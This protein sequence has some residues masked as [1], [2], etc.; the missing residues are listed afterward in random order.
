M[1]ELM[2]AIKAL[3]KKHGDNY[4]S[5]GLAF[6]NLTRHSTGIDALDFNIGGGLPEKRI[7]MLAGEY[8]SGKTTAWIN[9]AAQ[10]QK[11]GGQVV[12]LNSE[13]VFDPIW[14]AKFGL[15]SEKLIVVP[16]SCV[17]DLTDVAET[18]LMSGEVDLLV[19]D[20]VDSTPS[21]KE[22]EESA[23]K[24]SYGGIAKSVSLFMK[25]MIQVLHNPNLKLKTTIVIV[26]HIKTNISGYGPSQY[27]P[28]GKSLHDFSD[29]IIWLKRDSE[30]LGEKEKPV[31]MTIKLHTKKN[32][33]SV[34]FRIGSYDLHFRGYIDNNKS[35]IETGMMYGIIKKAGAW[36]S[37]GDVKECGLEGFISKLS[38]E[39]ING[40]KELIQKEVMEGNFD[41][42]V[43]ETPEVE[44]VEVKKPKKTK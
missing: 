30:L 28:G 29:I 11:R 24:G 5:M 6:P 36:Y 43:E 22:T 3:N 2:N 27:T 26:N 41:P 4:V 44:E 42:K 31:G 13:G 34:P 33:T 16:P 40:V 7:I 10:C 19:W 15:D 37:F 21:R 38:Q 18:L 9:M 1:S 25:K 20:S 8:S 39:Q 12:L 32:K 23:D 14:G 17:E 35:I